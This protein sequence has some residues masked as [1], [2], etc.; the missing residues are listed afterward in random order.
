M[1]A[2]S[3]RAQIGA[4]KPKTARAAM[5]AQSLEFIPL[6]FLLSQSKGSLN[7]ILNK[8]AGNHTCQF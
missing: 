3:A 8:K 2:S 5:A 4:A 7:N 6:S 1:S